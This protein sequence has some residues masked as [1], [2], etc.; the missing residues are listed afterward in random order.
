[1]TG[2]TKRPGVYSVIPRPD[3]WAWKT[4]RILEGPNSDTGASLEVKE[5]LIAPEDRPLPRSRRG[6]V[7]LRRELTPVDR[8]QATDRAQPAS[9]PM[10]HPSDLEQ[11]S[12]RGLNQRL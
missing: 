1:M 11:Y 8:L 6:T 2:K 12:I 10:Q 5:A 4:K 7:F 3:A 9:S